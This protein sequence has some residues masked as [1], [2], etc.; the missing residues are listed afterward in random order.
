MLKILNFFLTAPTH[1]GVPQQTFLMLCPKTLD[2]TLYLSKNLHWECFKH[3]PR[4][5]KKQKVQLT[6]SHTYLVFWLIKNFQVV[7]RNTSPGMSNST[8]CKA[9]V[10]ILAQNPYFFPTPTPNFETLFSLFFLFQKNLQSS[11]SSSFSLM[12]LLSIKYR[13]GGD[14]FL[15][16]TWKK[17]S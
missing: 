6:N 12:F 9:L 11:S 4:L 2:M 8:V 14:D 3:E 1:A 10:N 16:K 15:S 13:V 7:I 5:H 17:K